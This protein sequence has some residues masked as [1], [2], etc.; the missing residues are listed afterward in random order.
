[1]FKKILSLSMMLALALSL[2]AFAAP[3]RSPEV[4]PGKVEPYI[5]SDIIS[6]T[7]EVPPEPVDDTGIAPDEEKDPSGDDAS[8]PARAVTANDVFDDAAK[9]AAVSNGVVPADFDWASYILDR[10]FELDI[11]GAAPHED[12]VYSVPVV[13]AY[14]ADAKLLGGIGVAKDGAEVWTA[15][16]AA[17]SDKGEVESVIPAA[18][19]DQMLA[20]GVQVQFAIFVG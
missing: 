6:P 14:A 8:T 1:M 18:L 15:V 11:T 19:V 13:P 5:P 20:G 12:Y 16:K 4:V 2:A 7:P 10:L 17:V 9:L 3:V